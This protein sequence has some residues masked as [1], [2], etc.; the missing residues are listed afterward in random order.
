[1]IAE[2]P[3]ASFRGGFDS[4]KTE[5]LAI[6]G[7][8]LTHA[9]RKIRARRS[10]SLP[11]NRLNSTAVHL[12]PLPAERES[13]GIALENSDVAV[14]IPVSFSFVS[15]AFDNQVRSHYPSTSECFSPSL[16][17]GRGEGEQNTRSLG[18]RRFG[19]G[20]R[21]PPAGPPGFEPFIISSL[22]LRRRA[23]TFRAHHWFPAARES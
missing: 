16:G 17:R 1:M 3:S 4:Q 2:N 9:S 15:E 22:R 14:V 18:R 12:S 13:V 7:S 19:L 5:A 20:A 6:A 10:L 8:R 21:K 23:L 11:T